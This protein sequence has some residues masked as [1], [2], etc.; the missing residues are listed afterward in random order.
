MVE[1]ARRKP[2]ACLQVV[3][4]EI[5]HLVKDLGGSQA[6]CEEVEN[7]THANAHPPHAGPAPALLRVYSDSVSYLIHRKSIAAASSAL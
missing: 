6:R 3:R 7:I 5:R 1:V 2:K 4:F